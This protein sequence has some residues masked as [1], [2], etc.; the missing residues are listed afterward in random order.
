MERDWANLDSLALNMIVEKLIEPIDHIW[1]GSVCK[2]WHSIANLNH[3][4]DHQFRSNVMP[5]LTIPS[6]KSPEKRCLYSIPANRVYPLESTMLN[7]KRCCGSSH[8]WLATLDE[9]D[10]ITWVNPFKDVAPISLPPIDNYMVCK[11]YD[12]NVHKV[13]LSVDPITSPNDYVVAG[14]YTT[15]SSLAFIKAGQE[16][17]TYIQDTDH[18]GFIDITFYKGLVYA[19]WM[20][21]RFIN[22]VKN[23]NKGTNSLHVFKLELNDK[24]D[25]LMHLSKLESLGDNVLFV[26]DGDS[27]SVSTS[28]FSSY[29]QKDSIYYSDNYYNEVPVPYPR[30]PFDMG[31]YNIKHGSFGVHC[32]YKSYFKG[33]APPIWVVPPFQGN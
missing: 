4:H 27:M 10:V 18:F 28:Y 6:K 32:P 11:D 15:R 25:K 23:I 26:G 24:G 3:R 12:F 5:M 33:M 13:T 7:N 31:I 1:F 20:V 19:L 8:G 29:L 30:G 2:N 17:W 9:E 22:R 16:F 21:R 14:I